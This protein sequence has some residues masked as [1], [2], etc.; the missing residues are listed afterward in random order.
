MQCCFCLQVET[1]LI[2]YKAHCQ[3]ILDS[4][5][6]ANFQ[7][8][9]SLV[10]LILLF[11]YCSVN[12]MYLW[13]VALIHTFSAFLQVQDFLIHF[14]QGMPTHMLPILGC[15]ATVDLVVVCDFI[16]YRVSASFTTHE[17]AVVYCKLHVK[18]LWVYTPVETGSG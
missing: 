10:S 5:V 3:R 1:F 16:L 14:W 12:C 2:M 9:R 7:E 18:C 8:V 6:R 15:Q 4:V 17:A 13:P 11:L